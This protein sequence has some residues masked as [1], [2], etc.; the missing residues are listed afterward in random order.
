[1]CL[2]R[3]WATH[4]MDRIVHAEQAF[5]SDVGRAYKLAAKLGVAGVVLLPLAV[6]IGQY[7][8]DRFPDYSDLSAAVLIVCGIVLVLFAL[9]FAASKYYKV[10]VGPSY[11]YCYST[12]LT[13]KLVSWQDMQDVVAMDYYGLLYLYVYPSGSKNPITIPLWLNDMPEFRRVVRENAGPDHALT[14]HLEAYASP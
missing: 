7:R 9:F 2:D 11:V 4:Q 12:T 10:Y 14:K 5:S 8:T 3:N 1:M 13:Y 6:A